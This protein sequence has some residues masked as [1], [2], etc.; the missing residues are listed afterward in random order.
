MGAAKKK[1]KGTTKKWYTQQHAER[2]VKYARGEENNVQHER[3]FSVFHG[4][5]ICVCLLSH[6]K[7]DFDTAV[8]IVLLSQQ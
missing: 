1:K 4:V 3:R 5:I 2:K 7:H 8:Q 6:A